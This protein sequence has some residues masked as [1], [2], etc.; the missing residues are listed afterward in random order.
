MLL[1]LGLALS[2]SLGGFV[3]ESPRAATLVDRAVLAQIAPPPPPAPPPAVPSLQVE[4]LRA[5]LEQLKANEPG[6]AGSVVLLVSGVLVALAGAVFSYIGLLILALTGSPVILLP[7]L[8]GMVLGIG[9]SVGG[10]VW[11]GSSIRAKN[12]HR[13]DVRALE[14]QIEQLERPAEQPLLPPGLPPPSVQAPAPTLLLAT[15]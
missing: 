6:V 4:T 1:S 15:F 5:Q 13:R 14:Q 3:S 7:A 8:L 10:G 12:R 2:V 11:L 9:M